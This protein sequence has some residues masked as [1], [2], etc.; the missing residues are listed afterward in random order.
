MNKSKLP[1]VL[2]LFVL[3]T[4]CSKAHS[5]EVDG[6]KS[7]ISHKEVLTKL[8][9]MNFE[10]IIDKGTAIRAL[11]DYPLTPNSSFYSFGF[12]DDKL[13]SLTKGVKGTTKNLIIL[14][15]KFST[16]YGELKGAYA[17]TQIESVGEINSI[18]F[19]WEKDSDKIILNYSIVP[20]S[21]R[22]NLIYET[23]NKCYK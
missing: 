16:T 15:E 4:I 20:S 9:S 14:F 17:T 23:K 11:G 19:R 2:A 5:F 21:E 10:K 18:S 6:F 13:V 1:I 3:L 22:I 12:C 8:N 7:G